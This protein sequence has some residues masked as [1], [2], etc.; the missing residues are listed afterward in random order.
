MGWTWN[1]I[2]S[3]PVCREAWRNWLRAKRAKDPSFAKGQSE[4]STKVAG[5]PNAAFQ[6]FAADVNAKGCARMLY[7]VVAK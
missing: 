3:L 7:E 1:E 5:G 2:K 4:D 6:C